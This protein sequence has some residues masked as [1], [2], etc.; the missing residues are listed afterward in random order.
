VSREYRIRNN[1][2]VRGNIF[3]ASI[4]E[5]MRVNRLRWFGHVMRGNKCSKSCYENEAEGKAEKRKRKIKN[6]IVRYN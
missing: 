3:E 6:E 4:V 2:Y 5:N 1:K